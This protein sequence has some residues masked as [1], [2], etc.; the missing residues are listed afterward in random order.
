VV[1]VACIV[2][3]VGIHILGV[4][5][6]VVGGIHIPGVDIP[7]DILVVEDIAEHEVEVEIELVVELV[8]YPEFGIVLEHH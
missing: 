5:I 4:D 3:E 7:V 6:L 8:V 1:S 2:A